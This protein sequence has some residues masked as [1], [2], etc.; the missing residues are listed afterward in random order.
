MPLRPGVD[1]W[2]RVRDMGPSMRW[3]VPF[4][5][6]F[7]R[8]WQDLSE[9]QPMHAR[10][11]RDEIAKRLSIPAARDKTTLLA[12]EQMS[13]DGRTL[14]FRGDCENGK[15]ARPVMLVLV[16]VASNMVLDW[17]LGPSENAVGTVRL[18]KRVCDRYGIFDL[19]GSAFAGHLVASGMP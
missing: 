16:D 8:R 4:F 9:A 5:P 13:L 2:R 19:L 12:L 11:G 1:G 15:A 17:E 7:F 6:N 18:I 10:R 3:A 14:D